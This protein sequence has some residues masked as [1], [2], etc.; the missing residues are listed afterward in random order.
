[1]FARYFLSAIAAISIAGLFGGCAGAAA[2]GAPDTDTLTVFAAAS[3]AESFAELSAAFEAQHPTVN[4]AAHFAGS[5]TLRTQLEQGA[6]ADV[7]AP[8]DWQ[9]M[10]PLRDAGLL[11]DTPVYFVANRVTVVAPAHSDAVQSLSDL[12]KANV[13]I[14][15]AAAAVPAGAYTRRSLDLMADDAAF[16][17]GFAAAVLANVVTNE[18]SVRGVAQKVSLGEVDAGFVY[19]TDAAAPQHAGRLRAIAVP[20]HL[21]EAAQYPIATLAGAAQPAHAAK[22]VEFALSDDG[23]AILR[24]HGFAP[25]ANIACPCGS[26]TPDD[27]TAPTPALRRDG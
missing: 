3:L 27:S 2:P 23:L 17:P 6:S 21:T 20:L 4:V 14:A 16:P 11:A 12:A 5:Q 1:M 8:A 10:A 24:K 19:E 25:P 7:F 15:I 22:F 18:T 13:K 26:M 9:Q